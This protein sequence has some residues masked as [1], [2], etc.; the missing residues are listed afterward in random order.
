MTVQNIQTIFL[1]AR[2]RRKNSPQKGKLYLRS[3]KHWLW[4]FDIATQNNSISSLFHAETMEVFPLILVSS[5]V[6]QQFYWC[7]LNPSTTHL[8]R[9][10]NSEE[11]LTN[12]WLILM[13]S[14]ITLWRRQR[15]IM[16][17]RRERSPGGLPTW[18]LKLAGDDR[19]TCRCRSTGDRDAPPKISVL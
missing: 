7:D 14:C 11:T 2:G 13:S 6:S 19:R 3:N 17:E 4:Y 9:G 8:P 5:S 12:L 10:N 15:F 16:R 1:L 18:P